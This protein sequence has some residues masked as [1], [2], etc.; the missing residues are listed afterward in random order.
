LSYEGGGGG[1]IPS[2]GESLLVGFQ[3]PFAPDT[4]EIADDANAATYA[5][6]HYKPTNGRF[7]QLV[8]DLGANPSK[9]VTTTIGQGKIYVVNDPDAALYPE[10]WAG[11]DE[12]EEAGW[13]LK[14]S[15]NEFDR[16]VI[17]ATSG[18]IIEISN[19]SVGGTDKQVY[20]EAGQITG[21]V[22]V[23]GDGD[24]EFSTIDPFEAIS[25]TSIVPT[26]IY[27]YEDDEE[28]SRLLHANPFIQ[29]DLYIQ[30]LGS[31]RLIKVKYNANAASLGSPYYYNANT[32]QGE[33]DIA[34]N[35]D[36]YFFTSSE[37]QAHSDISTPFQPAVEIEG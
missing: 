19:E 31:R 3:L 21:L 35:A 33:C 6:V 29:K 16:V 15:T 18:Q 11:N 34:G 20:T 4:L 23:W 25:Y 36:S 1:F 13:V 32:M 14:L 28:D 5:S 7:G 30:T 8:A 27:F 10:V 2:N 26:P 12:D 22:A 9:Q 37:V 24:K 17:Q